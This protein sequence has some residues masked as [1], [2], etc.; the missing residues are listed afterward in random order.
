MHVVKTN[1]I[2]HHQVTWGPRGH[3]VRVA[4]HVSVVPALG[5]AEGNGW[6]Q[7]VAPPV[8]RPRVQPRVGDPLISERY[9]SFY[10]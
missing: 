8:R 3:E 1:E 2:I 10:K 7:D 4:A 5:P 6:L 9:K